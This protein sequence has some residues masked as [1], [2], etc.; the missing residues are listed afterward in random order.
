[1]TWISGGSSDA[2]FV[3]TLLMER[4]ILEKPRISGDSIHPS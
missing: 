4:A 3:E 1:M 2:I